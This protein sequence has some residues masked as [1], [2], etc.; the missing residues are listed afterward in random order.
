MRMKR[1]CVSAIVGYTLTQCAQARQVMHSSNHSPIT[2]VIRTFNDTSKD[3]MLAVQPRRG[4][5]GDEKLTAIGILS[6]IGH[7]HGEWSV[8]AQGWDNFIIEFPAPNTFPARSVA[9]WIARLQHETSND[10]V[11]EAIV[12]VSRLAVSDKVG[13]GLWHL[14]GTAQLNVNVP[15]GGAQNDARRGQTR[16]G[17]RR[18]RRG[19]Q[20]LIRRRRGLVPNVA[21]R[22]GVGKRG[23]R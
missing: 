1:N 6:R 12:I 17:V 5:R 10:A 4:R 7:A 8:V 9:K 11:K 20:Q 13:N 19:S 22:Q 18:R 2:W 14:L 23:R 21:A 15:H 16:R 3:G